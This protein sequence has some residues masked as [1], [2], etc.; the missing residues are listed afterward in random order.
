MIR[1]FSDL[2]AWRT[3]HELTLSVYKITKIFPRDELFGLVSQ[4]RRAATSVGANIAEGF[5]RNTRK[6]KINFYA[7]A[8]TSLDE[9]QNHMMIARD[10]KYISLDMYSQ[11]DKDSERVAQLITGLQR[12]AS[13]RER[14]H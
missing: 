11:F 12:S 4:S 2:L 1:R 8:H 3:A 7:T 13:D 10:L 6:D 5:G 14:S 9:L